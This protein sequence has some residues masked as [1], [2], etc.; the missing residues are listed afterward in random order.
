[1]FNL[2][3]IKRNLR[4]ILLNYTSAGRFRRE[5]HHPIIKILEQLSGFV[6]FAAVLNTDYWIIVSSSLF[7]S[8]TAMKAIE[9]CT[10]VGEELLG[11]LTSTGC[12]FESL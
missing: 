1:M 4:A 5:R 8:Y 9:C 12:R 10:P 6:R 11:K 7:S 3:S 2:R